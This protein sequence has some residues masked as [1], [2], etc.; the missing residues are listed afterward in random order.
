MD[1]M[2]ATKLLRDSGYTGTIVALTANAV[3]GQA[4]IFLQNGFD[5]FISKPID[6]RQLDF[7][8]HK[9]IH[10]KR[11]ENDIA[12]ALELDE[13]HKTDSDGGTDSEFDAMLKESLIRDARKTISI[14][15]EYCE[16]GTFADDDAL[17]AYTITVHG[18]KSSLG[19]IG[20]KSLSDRAKKLEDAGRNRELDVVETD[21]AGFLND[22]R[23]LVDKLAAEMQG[24][25]ASETEETDLHSKLMTLKEMC[26][27]YNR[28]GALDALAGIG[29]VASG[30]Q[31]MLDGI[32]ECV[33][34][35]DFDEAE[36]AIETFLIGV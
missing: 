27:D 12:T 25:D 21:T 18:I 20:E 33:L 8:L 15:E 22:L 6:I 24:G 4:E 1:G 11:P 5:A 29:K 28:K 7:V 17:R 16:N 19:A 3:A 31:E 9:Y 2:E 35:S 13:A 26:A 34:H 32:K 23:V 30:V 10:D 36:A 14:L